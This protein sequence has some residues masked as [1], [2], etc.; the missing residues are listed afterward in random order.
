MNNC[1]SINNL[2]K[3][4]SSKDSGSV[5]V[6]EDL[7]LLFP[8][9]KITSILGP[10]GCGKT[11]LLNLLAGLAKP[12][13]GTIVFPESCQLSVGYMMQE[14]LLLPWRTLKEN[15]Q[16]GAEVTKNKSTLQGKELKKNFTDFDLAKTM[17]NYPD[18]ASGGMKQRTALIRTLFYSPKI[19]LLDEPFSNLDFET[20]LKI[21]EYLLKY[22]FEKKA[23][24]I[25]VTHDI[26]DAVALSDKVII[27]SKR[28]TRVKKIIDIKLSIHKRNFATAYKSND[29]KKYFLEIWNEISTKL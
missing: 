17:N 9:G 27:L 15:A 16:L 12:T 25:L 10:S 13:R 14:D 22:Q 23:T 26:Q 21:Q 8:M 19:L 4:F 3:V 1:I 29:F 11:T 5:H 7:N 20:K 2:D 28:P 6:F 24:I 18:A